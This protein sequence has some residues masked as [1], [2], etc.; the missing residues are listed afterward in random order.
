MAA[1]LDRMRAGDAERAETEYGEV[2]THANVAQFLATNNWTCQL[3]RK[4]DQVWVQPGAVGERVVSVLLPREPAFVDYGK[5]LAEALQSIARV[6]DW[7]LSKLAEQVAAIHAD[8]FFVRI[9]QHSQDGTIPLRQ[10]TSLLESIDQMIRTAAITAYNPHSSGRGRV[11]G[12]V[13]DFL[14][15]DVRMGHTKKGSFIITVAARLD[16]LSDQKVFPR[17]E[18][19]KSG[20]PSEPGDDLVTPAETALPSFTRQV[21]TTLARSLDV[22]RRYAAKGDDFI[23]FDEA[24]NQGL[25]LPLVQAL[26][27]M[28][29]A[30]GV[31]SLDLNFEWAAAEPNRTNVPN[32]VILDR[33]VIE[34]LPEVERQLTRTIQPERV[35]IVGPV[36]ELK[37]SEAEGQ[38]MDDEQ[39]EIVVRADV[40][41]RLSRI[42]V[43]LSGRDYDWAIRAHRERLPFSVS[44]EL[45]KKGRS[46]HLKEPVD[47]DRSFLEFRLGPNADQASQ[48]DSAQ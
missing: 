48:E 34:V 38:V 47:V 33:D 15:D 11:P 8:L 40:N 4:F 18:P 2:L 29:D 25:R 10:A 12:A 42:V 27:D 6:Y 5:R 45:D 13:N 19:L 26:H 28:S 17:A 14:N 31:R 9:D 20:T 44:G 7:R 30:E 39:G 37:R 41:G 1:D 23:G 22:T 43:P 3:D 32:H 24:I 36:T 16:S 35:T 21:M 46:W